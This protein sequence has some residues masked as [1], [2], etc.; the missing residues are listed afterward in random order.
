VLVGVA[1][2]ALVSVT[3]GGTGSAATSGGSPDSE[4][5]VT[6]N[7]IHIGVIADV[8]NAAAPGL[9]QGAVDGVKA[10]ADYV[11]AHGKLAGRKVVVDFYDSKLTVD[12]AR[13]GVIRACE[14]DVAL[15]AT[16]ALFLDNI[17]PLVSCAD[18]TGAA[19]GLPDF[20]SIQT[21]FTH[22]CSPV[23]YNVGGT[24]MD[25]TTKDKHPQ[26]Y[27]SVVGAARYLKE[28]LK[29]SKGSWILGN[30]IQGTLDATLPL[31]AGERTVGLKGDN[32]LVG[33]RAPQSSYTPYVQKLKADGI[34]Y[35]ENYG[36]AH[37]LAEAQKEAAVQGVTVKA[38]NC[39]TVCYDKAYL[40][41]AGSVAEGTYVWVGEIPREEAKYNKAVATE[42]KAIP[43]AKINGF[44]SLA[45]ESALLFK[46]TIE[47][48]VKDQGNNGITRKNIFTALQ[49]MHNFNADGLRGTSDI[50]NH[51]GT[52]CFAVLQIKSGKFVRVYPAKKGTLDCKAHN[53]INLK[54]DNQISSS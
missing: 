2:A 4:V 49:S 7:E 29:L 10:W 44:S 46:A 50:A 37:N 54:Y 24:S 48:V 11:N 52:P 39:T 5:G 20:A 17:D 47:Q 12:D 30:D 45:W 27:H 23:S 15:V 13:N 53:I 42:V 28:K 41:D 35:V 18:K 31:V 19:T 9:F 25:C 43:P 8:D 34:D 22:M 32:F 3:F 38:W 40:D 36:A 14:N 16:S 1:A 21:T 6:A 51:T 26:T 33:G